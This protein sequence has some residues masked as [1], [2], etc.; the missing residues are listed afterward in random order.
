MQ[1]FNRLKESTRDLRMYAGSDVSKQAIAVLD[2]LYD[3]YC[4]DLIN[5]APDG[6]VRLQ[7]AIK[8]VT[9]LRNVFANDG[10]D[11]PKI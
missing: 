10:L 1:P 3:C 2:A 6:L 11:I 8:Q 9:L 4:Q 7:A 5:V